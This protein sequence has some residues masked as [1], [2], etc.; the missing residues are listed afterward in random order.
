MD[1]DASEVGN[2]L[3]ELDLHASDAIVLSTGWS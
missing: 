3:E 2:S 1:A